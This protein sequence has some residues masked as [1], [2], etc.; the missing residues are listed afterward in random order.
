MPKDFEKIYKG[1]GYQDGSEQD[2]ASMSYLARPYKDLW[3]LAIDASKY[4]EFGPSGDVADG[5]IKDA[6]M[7]WL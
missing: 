1:F 6:T 3:L 5:R 2:P 7:D 4:E